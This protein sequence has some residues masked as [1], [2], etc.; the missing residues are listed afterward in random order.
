MYAYITEQL[1]RLPQWHT[2]LLAML[3]GAVA[4][5]LPGAL[6]IRL[7]STPSMKG[8]LH[9]LPSVMRR[10]A[11][12]VDRQG[13]DPTQRSVPRVERACRYIQAGVWYSLSFLLFVSFLTLIL[14]WATTERSLSVLQTAGVLSYAFLLPSM[15]KILKA[16]GGRE[17]LAIRKARRDV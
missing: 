7:L 11:D 9:R 6:V 2:D 4:L 17:L 10:V 14:F 15:A 16:E 12:Y 3:W 13:Y 5:V 1:T 8:V